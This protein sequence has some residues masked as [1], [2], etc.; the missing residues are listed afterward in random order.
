VLVDDY[1]AISNENCVVVIWRGSQKGVKELRIRG[2]EGN[3]ARFEP[4][5][6]REPR[7]G[8]GEAAQ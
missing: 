5:T 3:N 7:F 6:E 2:R 1:R 8:L 4:V